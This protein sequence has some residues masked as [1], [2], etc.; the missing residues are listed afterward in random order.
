[1]FKVEHDRLGSGGVRAADLATDLRSRLTGPVAT[2]ITSGE[3][4]LPVRVRTK[5]DPRVGLKPLQQ[6]Y[7]FNNQ[8]DM[9]PF[10]ELTEPTLQAVQRDINRENRTRA[11]TASVVFSPEADPVRVAEAIQASL[12]KIRLDPGYTFKM[13][14]EVEEILKAKT[15]MLG[16]AF[17]GLLLIYLVLVAAT[18]SFL[19]PLVIMTAAPFAAGGVILA[20]HFQGTR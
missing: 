3:K 17:I 5:Q 7:L 19:Q 2:R 12:A 16:T 10:T 20:L 9:L 1:M 18:E 6:A 13:G 8:S 4:E 14:E 15:E 11:V